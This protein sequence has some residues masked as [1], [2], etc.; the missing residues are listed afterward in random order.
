MSVDYN[1]FKS[2]VK[3]DPYPYYAALRREEPVYRIPGTDFYAVSR[4]EDNAEMLKQPNLFSSMGMRVM[5]MSGFGAALGMVDS[6][7]MGALVASAGPADATDLPSPAELLRA[8]QE[9]PVDFGELLKSRSIIMSDPPV[10]TPMRAIVNRGFTPRRI[11]A[12]EARV[13]ELADEAI[14]RIR[15]RETFDLVT[16]L[17]VPIPVQVIAELLGVE[18]ERLDDFKRWSDAIVSGVSGSTAGTRPPELLAAFTELI[19]YFD[20]IVERRRREP[21]ED[22]VSVIAAAREGETRLTNLEVVM[23]CVLVLAAGNETTTNLIGNAVL[24]LLE[25]PDQMEQVRADPKLIPNLVEEALRY[26]SPVQALFR[27]VTADTEL[28]GT[29]LPAGTIVLPLFA[30]ANRDEKQFPDPDRFDVTRNSQGHLAFGYGVHFCLGASLARLE[31][32]VALEALL[33]QLPPFRA[34]NEQVE[35]IDSFLLRGPRR[36]PLALEAN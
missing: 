4:Y 19:Q 3:A 18:A 1:P 33:T 13:K 21:R 29:K 2:E 32:R 22:L 5:L 10:H 6:T 30:S 17:T 23:F 26:D 16:E 31:A 24:A 35:R 25:H 12:L 9:L 15:G 14:E 20:E 36:L 8:A 7:G 27:Q 34:V 11:A 28:A